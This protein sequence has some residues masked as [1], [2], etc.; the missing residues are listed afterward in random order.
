MFE[1]LLHGFP[2]AF[3]LASFGSNTERKLLML[4]L[5]LCIAI[6]SLLAFEQAWGG[7]VVI[8]VAGMSTSY[9]LIKNKLLSPVATYIT[10]IT[11]MVIVLTVN[12]LTGKTSLIETMPA[13]TFMAYR[14]GELHCKE[15]GLRVCMI[16]G[17][18]N[19][20]AY[21]VI[22]QTWG[23]AITEALFAVSNLW[24]YMKLRRAMRTSPV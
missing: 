13:L 14:F 3:A 12:H 2:V 4:N 16:I 18:I 24:Y 8:T 22:T 9:R 21:G 19:F 23:L 17:S 11:M 10:L 1:L 5:G 6:S 15:A 7:V 20:T